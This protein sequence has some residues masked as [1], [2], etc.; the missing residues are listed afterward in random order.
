ME[1]F[2]KTMVKTRNVLT[3]EFGKDGTVVRRIPS[4]LDFF[5][6]KIGETDLKK[7]LFIAAEYYNVNLN[8]GNELSPEEEI[9]HRHVK[10]Q[11]EFLKQFFPDAYKLLG[12][13]YWAF[14]LKCIRS[15]KLD[16]KILGKGDD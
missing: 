4:E 6:S 7:G 8:N 13:G 3:K 2:K 5:F 1:P 16:F 10:T 12:G 11:M 14:L 9:L 15:N